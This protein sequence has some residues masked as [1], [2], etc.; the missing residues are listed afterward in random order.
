MSA[1][2]T[3][4]RVIEETAHR[5]AAFLNACHACKPSHPWHGRDGNPFRDVA[6]MAHGR[7][8]TDAIAWLTARADEYDR[9]R[10]AIQPHRVQQ[11]PGEFA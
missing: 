2:W 7:L 4:E 6:F 11:P 9:E 1:E 5:S 8:P 10:S 3:M